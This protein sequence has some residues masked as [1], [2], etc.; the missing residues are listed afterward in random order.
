MG[1]GQAVRSPKQRIAVITAV[2]VAFVILL[3]LFTASSPFV[4]SD[5]EYPGVIVRSHDQLPAES[6][7][8]SASIRKRV[9]LKQR[10]LPHLVGYAEVVLAPNSELE[11]HV[12][13]NKYEVFTGLQGSGVVAV[14]KDPEVDPSHSADA[15]VRNVPV[16]PGVTV[17]VRP[18]FFH[19]IKNTGENDLVLLCLGISE[20]S[21]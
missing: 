13:P 20:K 3:K 11:W 14:A 16:G 4:P 1:T 2:A 8:D 5:D 18:Y 12:A 19:S 15:A 7:L 10:E 21:H 9:I 6:V 17:A